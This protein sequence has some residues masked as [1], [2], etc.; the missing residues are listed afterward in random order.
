M[1]EFIDGTRLKKMIMNHY[2]RQK[3]KG[4]FRLRIYFLDYECYLVYEIKIIIYFLYIRK[5]YNKTL[6]L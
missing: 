2:E 4:Y 3:K 6:L 1:N 5:I